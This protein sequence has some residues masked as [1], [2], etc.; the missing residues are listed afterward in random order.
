MVL[1]CMVRKLESAVF[2]DEVVWEAFLDNE[3]TF[4]M[5]YHLLNH[6]AMEM[7][8]IETMIKNMTEYYAKDC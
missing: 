8:R 5:N 7:R 4:N 3:G 6:L 1:H 2:S